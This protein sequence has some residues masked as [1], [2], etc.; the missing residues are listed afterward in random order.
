MKFAMFIVHGDDS[1]TPE[2]EAA[3]PDVD[4][5]FEYVRGKGAFVHAV[6]LLDPPE[7]KTVAQ[8]GGE[9]LVTDGPFAETREWIAGFAILECASMDEAL[10]IAGAEPSGVLRPARAP[11]GALLDAGRLTQPTAT[12]SMHMMLPSLSVNHAARPISGIVAMSP[13][14]LTPGMS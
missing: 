3:A 8:R 14:Q 10:E 9:L 13:S 7:A 5:W 1:V 12:S 4:E 2:D 11:A 6:R